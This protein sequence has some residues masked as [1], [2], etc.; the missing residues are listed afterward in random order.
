MNYE[1]SI[2]FGIIAAI[3]LTII[4]Y[5]KIMPKHMDGTFTE[6]VHQ[7]LHDYF[8]FKRLYLEDVMKFLFTFATIA[9]VV[10]GVLLLIS[11][12]PYGYYSKYSGW[13]S[14]STFGY[15]L[16]LLLGGP[17]ALRLAYESFMLFILLVKNTIEIN[18]KL[19]NTEN[20]SE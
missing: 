5:V 11:Q 8:H 2:P 20:D 3:V 13:H 10:C 7:K 18:N 1:F 9:C 16:A 15:G 17:I 6:D 19:K 12:N 4:L 14:E